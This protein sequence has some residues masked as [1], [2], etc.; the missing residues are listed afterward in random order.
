MIE[1]S[2]LLSD[3]IDSDYKDKERIDEIIG[4]IEKLGNKSLVID[5]SKKSLYHIA[6]VTVSN[7]VLALLS[8][9]YDCMQ[10]CG[11]NAENTMQ[12]LMPL[13]ISNINNIAEKGFVSSLTGPV[14]RNDV[15]TIIKH[16]DALPQQYA[17]IYAQLS[18]ILTGFA[19]QKH[20]E[21]DYLKLL[22][23]FNDYSNNCYKTK[24]K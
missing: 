8:I 22:Q 11:V 23:Y 24:E 5:S 1:K 18:M 6:N 2:V 16:L 14:E 12:T 13:I 15:G 3:L 19:Q 7:L 20:P 10:M 21:K 9:G 4:F 17:S